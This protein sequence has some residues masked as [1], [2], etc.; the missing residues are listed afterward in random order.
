MFLRTIN[1]SDKVALEKKLNI[2][3]SCP[4]TKALHI[5]HSYGYRVDISILNKLD[6]L[7]GLERLI[8]LTRKE[9]I[10]FHPMVADP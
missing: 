8:D 7:E 4:L 10:K 5:F 3:E 1:A 6:S 9:K 2:I